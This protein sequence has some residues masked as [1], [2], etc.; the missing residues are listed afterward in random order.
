M[1][2]TRIIISANPEVVYSTLNEVFD[3][4]YVHAGDVIT[5]QTNA[6]ID[7]TVT[8]SKRCTLDLG[9]NSLFASVS[10]A[11]VIKNGVTIDIVNGTISTLHQQGVEDLI[12]VQGSK[13]SLIL[14]E[15][16]TISNCGVSIH[17]KKRGG[18]VVEGARIQ[19]TNDQPAILVEDPSSTVVVN[20]GAISSQGF[21]VAVSNEGSLVVNGG[22]ITNGADACVCNEEPS[23]PEVEET[24][25]EEIPEEVEPEVVEDVTEPEVEVVEI[26]E[27]ELQVVKEEPEVMEEEPVIEIQLE[28]P[29]PSIVQIVEK[30]EDYS[31]KS[32]HIA[33]KINLY[34]T[35]SRKHILCSWAG[36]LTIISTNHYSAEGE[37][38]FLVKFKIPGSGCVASG[39]AIV[40]E[41]L[42]F[43][44]EV[45]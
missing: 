31:N 42:K 33:K 19:S 11:I 40:E 21:A 43:T 17:A 15:G 29:D 6:V 41:I 18:V 14:R 23:E 2:E 24:I 28:E 34:K 35:P 26:S 4:G 36:A 39:F 12:V 32:V 44:K 25:V 20:S 13:T 10:S 9:G 1:E 22:D 27:P 30:H 45:Q 37:E 3:S 16:V 8:I 38:Y 5:L 7:S